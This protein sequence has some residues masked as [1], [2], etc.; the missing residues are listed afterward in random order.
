MLFFV[1]PAAGASDDWSKSIGVKYVYTIEVRPDMND[2]NGFVLPA[3]QIVPTSEEVWAALK[4]IAD[5]V[6]A[7]P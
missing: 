3:A 4:V 2:W 5:R 1:D 7:L 6:I